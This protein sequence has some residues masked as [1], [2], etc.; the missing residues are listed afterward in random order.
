MPQGDARPMTTAQARALLAA[1][2]RA[3][4]RG[5]DPLPEDSTGGLPGGYTP[6]DEH[7]LVCAP[8]VVLLALTGGKDA[9]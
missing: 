8:V 2:V 4:R 1:R 3:C 9:E 7:C 6:H 5:W